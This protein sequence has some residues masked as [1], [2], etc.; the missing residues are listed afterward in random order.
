ML[1]WSA[2]IVGMVA[3]TSLPGWGVVLLSGAICG[4]QYWLSPTIISYFM[5]KNDRMTDEY[6]VYCHEVTGIASR[7][8]HFSTSKN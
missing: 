7:V 6:T 3:A 2:W 8:C 4:L 5:R 1:H